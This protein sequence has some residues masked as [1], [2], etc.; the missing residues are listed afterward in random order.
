M[1]DKPY[2]N[3]LQIAYAED[4]PI[5]N[6]EYLGVD[7][8][9]ISA[10]NRAGYYTMRALLKAKQSDLREIPQF[11][12]L[13]MRRLMI[14]LENYH[15]LGEMIMLHES[16][17]RSIPPWARWQ[18]CR[19]WEEQQALHSL[20]KIQP[21]KCHDIWVRWLKGEKQAAI[22]ESEGLQVHQVSAIV[23]K[24]RSLIGEWLASQNP[25]ELFGVSSAP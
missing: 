22:A 12:A 13:S 25:L 11:A 17:D 9:I 20:D 2:A 16:S 24:T 5:S 19:V 10:L 6:L 4:H 21:E 8:R 18:A 14:G 1:S 7:A 15:R 23:K 3:A